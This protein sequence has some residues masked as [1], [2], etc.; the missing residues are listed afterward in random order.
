MSSVALLTPYS[1]DRALPRLDAVVD[2]DRTLPPLEAVVRGKA[3]EIGLERYRL[4]RPMTGVMNGEVELPPISW[5]RTATTETESW[6]VKRG[7]EDGVEDGL[8]RTD[9]GWQGKEKDMGVHGWIDECAAGGEEK[10]AVK[11]NMSGIAALFNAAERRDEL[12]AE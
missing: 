9:V 7:T 2:I 12:R 3:E 5:N 10:S 1:V 11:E 8:R 6:N 4:L